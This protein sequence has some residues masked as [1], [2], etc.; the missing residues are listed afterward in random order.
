MRFPVVNTV[1][2]RAE[3]VEIRGT[4]AAGG[5]GDAVAC[6]LSLSVTHTPGKLSHFALRHPILGDYDSE[7]FNHDPENPQA[8]HLHLMS[9]LQRFTPEKFERWKG[10]QTK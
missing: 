5:L 7:M 8:M 9:M 10:T 1:T 4:A 6:D 2:G 3:L